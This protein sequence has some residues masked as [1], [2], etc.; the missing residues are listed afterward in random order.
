MWETIATE[1]AAESRLWGDA[2]RADRTAEP[3]FSPLAE[4]R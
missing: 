2:L 4:S 3:V 1:A